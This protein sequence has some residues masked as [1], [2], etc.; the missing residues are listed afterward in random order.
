[1]YLFSHTLSYRRVL[2]KVPVATLNRQLSRVKNEA[3]VGLGG[4]K[5]Q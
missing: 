2:A 3:K 1:M 5:T 4:R